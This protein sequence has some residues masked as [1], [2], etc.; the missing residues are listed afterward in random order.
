MNLMFENQTKVQVLGS[1]SK[2]N[3]T[4][5]EGGNDALLVDAG[6]SGRELTHRLDSTGTSVDQLTG[7]ILTHEH[8]DHVRGLK[9]L[10][11]KAKIPTWGNE[12]TIAHLGSQGYP[13]DQ[14]MTFCTG[15][16]F[17]V[18]QMSVSSFPVPHDAYDPCG[19]TIDVN[20]IRVGVL[21][22][23]GY[24]TEEVREAACKCHILFLEANYDVQMLSEDTKRPWA[25]KQRI[26]AR[27]GHL[28][29]TQASELL[30]SFKG[31]NSPL[32]HIFLGH[33]S[34]DC[35]EPSL[36]ISAIQQGTRAA[37]MD[38]VEIHLT[39]QSKPSEAVIL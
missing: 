15:E 20:G 29:N 23:L 27:H 12:Q 5:I 6:L 8:N 19:F 21:T 13:S 39:H 3:A 35:N 22:D 26:S 16:E 11:K 24:C 37:G 7:I 31:S 28:S 30:A 2:G 32:R 25:T 33:M 17:L 14:W 1:G 34:E 9:G 18:G 4:L 36:A 38:A 10:L